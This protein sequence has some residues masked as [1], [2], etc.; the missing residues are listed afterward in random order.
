MSIDPEQLLKLAKDRH[1]PA[2][3]TLG[4]PMVINIVD[5]LRRLQARRHT[6]EEVSEQERE[7]HKEL[8]DLEEA[9]GQ[10]ISLETLRKR[11][12]DTF[13]NFQYVMCLLKIQEES[14]DR[15]KAQWQA[16]VLEELINQTSQYKEANPV[17]GLAGH[18][19]ERL[20]RQSEEAPCSSTSPS[21]SPS[22]SC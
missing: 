15:L 21:A 19:V 22:A 9:V 14:L 12:G 13:T 8:D 4:W 18:M 1:G 6:A 7:F 17:R 5:E 20:H 2:G 10:S 16:E 3:V 11:I